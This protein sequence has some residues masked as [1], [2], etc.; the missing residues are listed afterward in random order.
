MS[1]LVIFLLSA[2]VVV[3]AGV[4]LSRDAGVIS[5]VTGLGGAWIGAVLLA[6]A[7]SLPELLTGI[8]AVQAGNV[9]M[10]VSEVFGSNMANML[11]LA[12]ADLAVRRRHVLARVE[13]NQAL[14][15]GLAI[16]LTATAAA[17]LL[18]GETLVFGPVGWAPILIVFGYLSGMR[19]LHL[20]RS[21]PPFQ[22]AELP[23]SGGK[24]GPRL[25]RAIAGFSIAAL[26]TLLAANALADSAADVADEFGLGRTFVGVT[27]LALTTSL[28]EVTVTVASIRSGAYDLAVGNLLGSNTFNMVILLA[29]DIADGGGSVL[30]RAEPAVMLSALFGILL[31]A[32]TMMEILNRTERR[33]WILEPDALLRIGMYGLG[34]VLIY[35][36]G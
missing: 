33:V 22:A 35:Q 9:S 24:N 1:P 19:L 5:E 8:F 36:A 29:L 18:T 11:I 15:G 10:A 23:G 21:Q 14:V 27:L 25:R 6:G 17:A 4:R 7:T 20:N 28:P 2:A 31:T 34:L 3:A 13:I 30:N 32:Q 16:G 26:A 12:V